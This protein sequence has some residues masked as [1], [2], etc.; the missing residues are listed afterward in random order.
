MEILKKILKK[1]LPPIFFPTIFKECVN[2]FIKGEN[3]IIYEDNFYNRTAFINK[4]ISEFKNCNY[5][6]IGIAD[7]NNFNSIPLPLKNKIGVD[8]AVGGTHKMTS[9]EFFEKLYGYAGELI[10]N[11][12]DH[13]GLMNGVDE[14]YI[15]SIYKKIR[16]PL[17]VMGGIGSISEVSNIFKKYDIIGVAC[18]SLFIYK[19]RNRAVLINYPKKEIL[20]NLE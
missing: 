4:S 8:P 1:L 19:G 11:N 14:K 5:L 9:D 18:G 6:E 17:V 2:Y 20:S 16:I 3:K 10:I 7:N 12:I 15:E 13:D